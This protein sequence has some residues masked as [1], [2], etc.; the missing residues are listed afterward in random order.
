MRAI[1]HKIIMYSEIVNIFSY[2]VDAVDSALVPVE[3]CRTSASLQPIQN[4][5]K[6]LGHTSRVNSLRQNKE[7][8]TLKRTSRKEWFLSLIARLYSTINT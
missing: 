5:R 7:N 3:L 2:W 6:M 8:N 4:V 1:V